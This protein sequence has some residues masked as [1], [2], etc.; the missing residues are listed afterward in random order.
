MTEMLAPGMTDKARTVSDMMIFQSGAMKKKDRDKQQ[1]PDDM[2]LPFSG[3]SIPVEIPDKGSLSKAVKGKAL[4]A[5]DNF[6]LPGFSKDD[7]AVD[8][9]DFLEKELSNNAMEKA[10]EKMGDTFGGGMMDIEKNGNEADSK[11]NSLFEL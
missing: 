3:I 2:E 9:G 5:A 4:G 10:S 8:S 1:D 7:M 6:K 11:I